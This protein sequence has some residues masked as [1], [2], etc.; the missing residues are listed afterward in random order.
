[1]LDWHRMR[2]KGRET[3][4]L[5]DYNTASRTYDNTRTHSEVVIDCL[6]KEFNFPI[7]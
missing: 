1:M 3:I 4:Q 6:I 7:R 2:T 5:I